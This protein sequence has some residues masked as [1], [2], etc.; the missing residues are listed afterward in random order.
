MS[1]PDLGRMGKLRRV[2]RLSAQGKGIAASIVDSFRESTVREESEMVRQILLGSSVEQSVDTLVSR[3]D[4]SREILL[5]VVSQA[6]VNAVEASRRADKLTSLFEHWVWM[7]Q[8]RV[9]EQRIMETRSILVSGILGGVTAMISAL[10]PVL[11]SFQLTLGAQPAPASTSYLG[12]LFVLPAA[13]FLGFF[14][15]PRRAYVNV[16]VSVAA[17]VLVT[18]FFSPLV[19]AI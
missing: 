4:H 2:L 5:Y 8:Q 13:S 17:F 18:Y 12:I 1:S 3:D 9:I 16:A 11:S 19:V 6:K 15:S 10:A 14:F 7:K